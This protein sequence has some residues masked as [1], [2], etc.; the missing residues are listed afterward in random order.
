MS[1]GILAKFSLLTPP[2]DWLSPAKDKDPLSKN[3][4][5]LSMTLNFIKR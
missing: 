4:G 3:E 2:V 5:V 1:L